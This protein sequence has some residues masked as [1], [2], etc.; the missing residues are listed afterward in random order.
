MGWGMPERNVRNIKKRG[1]RINAVIFTGMGAVLLFFIISGMLIASN[2]KLLRANSQ[3][4]AAT[5]ETI[6]NLE[7]LMS[8]MKDAETGQRG[9]VL[10]GK[11]SY[12]A[13]YNAAVPQIDERLGALERL[14]AHNDAYRARIPAMRQLV[15][16][17]LAELQETIDLRRMQGFDAALNVMETDRG[18]NAMDALRNHADAM[19]AEEQRIR[20]ERIAE[21]DAAYRIALISGAF[22]CILGVLLSFAVAFLVRRV[23]L[24]RAREEWL[25]A[26]EFGLAAAMAGDMRIEEL[27]HNVL[28]FMAEYFDAHAGALF[29]RRDGHYAH[30]AGYGLIDDGSVT[31]KFMPGEGLLGQAVKDCR[32]FVVRDVPDGYMKIS[33]ALGSEKP[34]HLLIAPAMKND[35][36]NAVFELG[37]IHDLD[38]AA[39][40]LLERMAALI[41]VA[42]QAADYREN[43]Q[44]LLEETQRQ[45]EELQAQGEELRVSNEELEEQ[46]RILKESQIRLEQQQA[47]LEQTNSHLE[48]QAQMLETQRDDL[49]QAQVSVVM[50]AQEL[51]RASQY[52]SDFL[53]NMSHEL[54]TPLNSSLILA[55]LLSDNAGGNLTDEQVK[56]AQTIQNSGND[57]LALINDILDLSKIEAGHMEL[58]PEAVTLERMLADLQRVF[59][60]MAE[61]KGLVFSVSVAAACPRIIETDRMRTEQVLRN[62]LSNAIKFTETGSVILSVARGADGNIA[63]SVKDTGIGIPYDQQEQVFE[64]FRQADSTISRKYGGTG[65]GLSISR[66]LVRLLGG[67]LHM[68]SV[69]GKGTIFTVSLPE[70]FSADLATTSRMP[71]VTFVK[72]QEPAVGKDEA[73]SAFGSIEDDRDH[74][75][76]GKRL[77]MVIEDDEAFAR[78]LYE[79]AHEMNFQCIIATTADE[80][81]ALSKRFMPHAVLLDVRLPDNSGLSVLDR[82]KRSPRTRH[83]PVHVVSASDY[84]ETALSMGAIGYMIKPV[85]REE[86]VEAMKNLEAKLEQEMRRILIVEDDQVQRESLGKLLGSAS[87]DTIGVGT[88][89]ESLDQLKKKNFDCMVLDLSLPD[90]SGYTLLETLSKEDSYSFPPV[91]VYTG[92]DLSANEEERLRRYS[93]SIIIKG[94]KSP[95]RLLDEVTLFLHQ[96]VAE[97]PPESQKML[98]KARNRDAVLEGRRIL[99][100][101]DD[102]ANVYA[103]TS[104]LEPRGAVL[105]VARNG[106]EALAALEGRKNIDLVLM[107]M[108]MPEMDGITATR[109]IRKNKAWQKLPVIMLTA[110]AMKNDQEQCL[111]AGA[112]DYMAKPL[113]V[114]KL[115]SLVRVWM[116]R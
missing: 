6:K 91:I 50:K 106:R 86:L 45:A 22:V 107:D 95:E 26:G 23:E 100:V 18:R 65:L 46:G 20:E 36:V 48:E 37:F 33:S 11:D 112:N 103:L 110:K 35:N 28:K 78:I 74:L 63:F 21:M 34:R 93:K 51:E 52:K 15:D 49:E 73:Q 67:A 96:V 17:K 83:I 82:L 2:T 9:Y 108:M 32:P 55:K 105:E 104:I 1:A 43:L 71:A 59:E 90:A 25:Q 75:E 30:V 44:N 5:H 40:E 4:V 116:P 98:E 115:L 69:P 13:P 77:I 97:L 70:K 53:A 29:T 42:V 19:R 99:I 24:N 12:L 10:M 88:V 72:E 14:V 8:Y 68:E 58:R 80:T 92:H 7:E 54:R 16:D 89:A 109:E 3:A 27:G 102:V 113:D 61:A 79:L 64:A 60:P 111:A 87:V 31:E 94:A 56:F 62:L 84:A 57:L 47:E 85:K 66:Q 81:L 39:I 76:K 41:G 101:E 114:E 38:E